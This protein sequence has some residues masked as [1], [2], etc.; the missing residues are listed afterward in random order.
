MPEQNKPFVRSPEVKEILDDNLPEVAQIVLNAYAS[1][2]LQNAIKMG[3]DGWQ[4][5]VKS[6][7][8]SLKRKVSSFTISRKMKLSFSY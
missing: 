7:G 1:G 3:H 2:E 6:V 5:W 8:K 4:K